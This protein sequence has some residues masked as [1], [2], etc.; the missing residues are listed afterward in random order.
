MKMMTEREAWEYLAKDYKSDERKC[1][2]SGVCS[3]VSQVRYW[4]QLISEDTLRSMEKKLAD[5]SHRKGKSIGEYIW[6]P[7]DFKSRIAFCARM[8]R[9]LKRKTVRA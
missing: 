3:C 4:M 6:K 7:E 8:A 2:F 5:E 9:S 1:C